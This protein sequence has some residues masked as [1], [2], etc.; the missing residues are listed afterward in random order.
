MP[1]PPTLGDVRYLFDE[2]S[3][4]FGLWISRLRKDMTCVGEPPVEVLMPLGTMDPD[5]IPV[6]ADRG[7]I[8]I[9]KN[10]HIRTQ[11]EEAELAVTH[12]LR[13]ACLLEPVKNANRWDFS[14]MV[15]RHWDAIADL[16]S[17]TEATWLA[18]HRDRVRVRA[19]QP[20]MPERSREGHL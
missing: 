7:W 10:W 18:V 13:V 12:G 19:F 5:W 3:R 9:T 8:A 16:T 2:D 4:G 15:F 1:E 14:R 6:A 11:P 20:G 17:R